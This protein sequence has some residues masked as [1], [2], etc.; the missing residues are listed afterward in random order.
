MT[1]TWESPLWIVQIMTHEKQHGKPDIRMQMHVC[2]KEE[3]LKIECGC[4]CVVPQSLFGKCVSVKW[5][6]VKTQRMSKLD[7]HLQTFVL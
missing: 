2:M 1:F 5:H 6:A 7:E 3:Q 4:K